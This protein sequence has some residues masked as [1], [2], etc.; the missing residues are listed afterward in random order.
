MPQYTAMQ[1]PLPRDGPVLRPEEPVAPRGDLIARLEGLTSD[2]AV[3]DPSN[4][5]GHRGLSRELAAQPIRDVP[6]RAG[7]NHDRPSLSAVSKPGRTRRVRR[8][9]AR[10]SMG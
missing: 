1:T 3:R 7:S 8:S 9:Q 4:Q 2:R 10:T 6:P 5:R